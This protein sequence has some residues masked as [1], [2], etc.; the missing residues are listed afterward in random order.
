DFDVADKLYFE[1]LTPEDVE[2]V[3]ELEKP[4]GAVVQ[5]GGQ[6]A[7]KLAKALTDMGVPIL[8][9]SSDGVDAAE[10][11]ERFDEILQQCRIPRAAGKT[12]FTTEEALGA[13][14]EV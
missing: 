7:I 9:T 5:F 14:H 2:A 6:T 4:G 1:P 3:V 13:A 8:G 12:V 11:R 10:D